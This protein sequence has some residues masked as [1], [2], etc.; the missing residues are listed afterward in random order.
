[1]LRSDDTAVSDT[2]Y[3]E[4]DSTLD[5]VVTEES[6]IPIR[7]PIQVKAGESL[8]IPEGKTDPF[9]H[10]ENTIHIFDRNGNER[11]RYEMNPE[12]TA[13]VPAN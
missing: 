8:S 3:M 10:V 9:G 6:S 11:V 4:E 5:K 7:P 2:I 1:M 13:F 12:G